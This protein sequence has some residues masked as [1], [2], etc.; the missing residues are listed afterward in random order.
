MRKTTFTRIASYLMVLAMV[1]SLTAAF[2]VGVSAEG[3]AQAQW[4]T[5]AANLTNEGTLQEALNAA[6][7][8]NSITYIKVMDNID[9]G[10]SNVKATGGTF[11]LDLNGKTVT[12]TSYTFYVKNAVDITITDTSAE[13]TGKIESTDSGAAA[14]MTLDTSAINL[15]IA[16][17]AFVGTTAIN[18]KL[19]TG[20][21]T[22]INLT[23]TGGTLQPTGS[24]HISWGSTGVLDLSA[25]GKYLDG[26]N[27]FNS[28]GST[29]TLPSEKIILPEG[30][31]IYQNDEKVTEMLYGYYYTVNG[32]YVEPETTP[33]ETTSEPEE[34]TSEPEETSSEEPAPEDPIPEEP[35]VE[36]QW[37]AD[38]D[39]PNSGTLQEA[40]EAAAD[41][42]SITYIKVMNDTTL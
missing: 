24:G 17:G 37:G 8:D 23:I 16:G 1:F 7:G 25:Y 26:V 32:T 20:G 34:T 41:D 36:A 2:A 30:F 18:T 40:L 28:T 35:T 11:T 31:D 12:A 38:T 9:L 22:A 6:A 4:G 13:Q 42:S 5:D 29:I 3:T 14:I 15:T 10:D 19:S 27:I 39:Q 33:E 21:T